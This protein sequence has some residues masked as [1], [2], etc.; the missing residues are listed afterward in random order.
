[1]RRLL[2]R[3]GGIGDCITC[4]PV[5]QYL[6]SE[7]TEAWVP[8]SVVPLVQFGQ[9]TRPI[10]STGL[11]LVGLEDIEVPAALRAALAQFDEIVSW[12]G[13]NRDSFREAALSL[14]PHWRFLP[15]LPPADYSGN[16]TDFHAKR[17]GAPLGLKPQI[18]VTPLQPRAAVVIHPFSGGRRKNWPLERFEEVARKLPLTVEWT[19]GPEEELRDAQRFDNLLELA[20][21]IRGA[22]LYIGNDSG[23]TH[24]A[25][26]TGTPTL[27][28]FGN[29]DARVWA[30]RGERVSLI[31]RESL[32]AVGVEEVVSAASKILCN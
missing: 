24:L 10:S 14:N 6:A 13:T 4:F 17:A 2:I 29:S 8:L 25:A 23:I 20:R 11:D 26:A 32:E 19:A 16:A 9:R 18:N 3:P 27:A 15:A 22:R 31:V 5:M 28:L 12:Y 21:W 30:P 1:M 7:Y